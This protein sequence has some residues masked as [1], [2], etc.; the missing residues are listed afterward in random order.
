MRR[1]LQRQL[2]D[3]HPDRLQISSEPRRVTVAARTAYERA[4]TMSHQR[5]RFSAKTPSSLCRVLWG[6]SS[7]WL[8]ACTGAELEVPPTHPGHPQARSGRVART[9]ALTPAYALETGASQDAAPSQEHA[10]H[11]HGSQV[12]PASDKA[13]HDASEPAAAF[14]CPMHPEVVRAEPGKC[15]I[16]GMDLVPKKDAK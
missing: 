5:A 15:P 16:C 8:V 3:P 10:H 4:T 13:T 7:L 11:H 14:T 1:Q 6:I 2:S 12:A 9:E